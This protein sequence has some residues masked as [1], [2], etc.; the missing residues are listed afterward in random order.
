MK[1]VFVAGR[2]RDVSPQI[3]IVRY[4]TVNLSIKNGEL[5]K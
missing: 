1:T 2:D 5:W 4:I 3:R